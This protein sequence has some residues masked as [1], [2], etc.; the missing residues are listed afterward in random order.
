MGRPEPTEEERDARRTALLDAAV[1][2]IRAHGPGVS[3]E[4]LAKA[5]GV[6]KPIL[7]RHFGHRDGMTTALATRFALGLEATLQAA[8]VG[9]NAPRET[10][11]KTIDAYLEFV[12]RDPEVYHF[13]VRRLMANEQTPGAPAELTVGNFLRQVSAQVALV[14]GEQLRTAGVDSGGAEP[15]AHGI[16][17]MVHAAGDWW[18]ERQ[19]MPRARLVEYIVG[20]LWGGFVGIGLGPANRGEAQI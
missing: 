2:A 18:L 8:M 13:L 14:L 5:A 4:D 12:E 16:V 10:L 11:E 17:G 9:G 6:T 1:G 15:L 3:M 19:V 7:Y 20:L